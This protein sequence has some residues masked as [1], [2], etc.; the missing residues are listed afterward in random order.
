MAGVMSAFSIAS[1]M[2][3]LAVLRREMRLFSSLCERF[4]A[5]VS[6]GGLG[7]DPAVEREKN[8]Q[9]DAE[10]DADGS[11]RNGLAP[12]PANES[13]DPHADHAAQN[14]QRWRCWC[15][16]VKLPITMKENMASPVRTTMSVFWCFRKIANGDFIPGSPRGAAVSDKGTHLTDSAELFYPLPSRAVLKGAFPRRRRIAAAASSEGLGRPSVERSPRSG[17]RRAF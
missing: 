10:H 15:R 7:P 17:S 6:I 12:P 13:E 1:L 5:S 14:G 8:A 2:N 16:T 11:E 4:P 3:W 9:D